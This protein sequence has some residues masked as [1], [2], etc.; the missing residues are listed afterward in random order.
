MRDFKT[1]REAMTPLIAGGERPTARMCVIMAELEER[2][3]N[4]QGLVREW[5]ARG[6]RAP[7]DATWVAD[8]HWSRQWAPDIARRAGLFA[9]RGVAA[10]LPDEPLQRR[11]PLEE[12]A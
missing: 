12:E 8:G 2:E 11:N 4:A 3:H 10:M 1:A 5:L 6:S 7:R 9:Y